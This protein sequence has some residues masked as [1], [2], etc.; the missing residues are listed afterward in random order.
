MRGKKTLFTCSKGIYCM[1]KQWMVRYRTFVYEIMPTGSDKL[2]NALTSMFKPYD[3]FI[4]GFLAGMAGELKARGLDVDYSPESESITLRA[5]NLSSDD[6]MDK[7][8]DSMKN[9]LNS[10]K[11]F[12]NHLGKECSALSSSGWFCD[13]GDFSGDEDLV[14]YEVTLVTPPENGS[15]WVA[16]VVGKV[17]IYDNYDGTYDITHKMWNTHSLVK[18]YNPDTDKAMLDWWIEELKGIYDEDELWRRVMVVQ[19]DSGFEI[20]KPKR[21]HKQ[22]HT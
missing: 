15:V 9:L 17:T 5:G 14:A 20:R 16:Y 11:G 13:Y 21:G 7:V 6:V 2:D 1:P 8:Y 3:N 4:N 12:L 18:D 19:T 10:Y 22:T